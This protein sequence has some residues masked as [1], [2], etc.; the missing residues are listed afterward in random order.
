M[1]RWKKGLVLLIAVALGGTAVVAT[2]YIKFSSTYSYTVK[3]LGARVQL[4]AS[5]GD[6]L[7]DGYVLKN[8]SGSP[9]AKYTLELGTWAVGTNKTLTAAFGIVNLENVFLRVTRIDVSVGGANVVLYLHENE[10]L[11]ANT[12]A[13]WDASQSET[14]VVSEDACDANMNGR[15]LRYWNG[16]AGVVTHLSDGIILEKKEAGDGYNG[17]LTVLTYHSDTATAVVAA[18]ADSPAGRKV[19]LDPS[20]DT[21]ADVACGAAGKTLTDSNVVWV[22]ITVAAVSEAA[23]S[24]DM[25]IYFTSLGT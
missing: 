10:S 1:E 18:N 15:K 7:G 13:T 21:N 6:P 9:A 3:T 20:T 17:D 22:E 11:A 5:D 4:I 2:Q 19:W 8:Q 23:I 12:A 14:A 25:N 24:G 16:V